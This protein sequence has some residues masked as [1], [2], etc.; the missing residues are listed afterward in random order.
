MAKTKK[1]K[2]D[3]FVWGGFHPFSYHPIVFNFVPDLKGKV[4]VDC[5]CGKGVWGYLIR[6]VRSMQ[7]CKII[8]IDLDPNY[9]SYC[10]VHNVY[11]KLIKSDISTL[12]LKDSSVDFL[13]CSEVIEHLPKKKGLK[14]LDEVGR[15]MKPGGRAIIT[16]PNVSIDT[17]IKEGKDSHSSIWSTEDFA[18]RK[19]KV[20]GMGI[21]LN[22]GIA[23]W[24][25][26]YVLALG[27]LL[28]PISYLFPSI[29]GYLIS[30]KNF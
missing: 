23:K 13:I 24:Y 18:E 4:V 1:K 21:K 28:T 12:P 27:Y 3:N 9:L 2:E 20:Y 5:G 16:T 14:F 10:K 17:F 26:F 8:G 25:T 7:N 30:V 6:S 11:D 19:Y 15:V 29:G 22:P